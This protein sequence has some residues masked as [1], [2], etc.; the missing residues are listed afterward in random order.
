[1]MTLLRS[2]I[3]RKVGN[4]ATRQNADANEWHSHKEANVRWRSIMAKYRSPLSEAACHRGPF[5]ASDKGDWID[6]LN[7]DLG[8]GTLGPNSKN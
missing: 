4:P 5:L 1:M 3:G 7:D 8:V 2:F 6:H